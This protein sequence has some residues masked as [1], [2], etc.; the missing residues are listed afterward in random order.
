MYHGIQFGFIIIIDQ[1]TTSSFLIIKCIY[2]Y[3]FFSGESAIVLGQSIA[4]NNTL[5]ILNLAYN[6]LGDEVIFFFYIFTSLVL[7]SLYIF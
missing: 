3:L 1:Y 4:Q 2:V 6:N 7:Y 5:K